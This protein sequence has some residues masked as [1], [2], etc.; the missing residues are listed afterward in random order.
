MNQWSKKEVK[1]ASEK[2][3]FQTIIPPSKENFKQLFESEIQGQ[4]ELWAHLYGYKL[5][6]V[7]N[8]GIDKTVEF[9]KWR[10]QYELEFK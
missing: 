7:A 4:L 3:V 8:K 6:K 5:S 10:N 9:I 2:V 1:V